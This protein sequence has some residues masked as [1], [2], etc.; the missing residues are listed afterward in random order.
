M[1]LT[2]AEARARAAAVSQVAYDIALDLTA[3]DAAGYGLRQEIAFTAH[4]SSTFL[5]LTGA[6]DLETRLDGRPVDVRYDG[7]RLHLDGLDA[8]R[9]RHRLV[10]TARLPY[11][12]DGAG[13]HRMVDPADGEVYLGAYVGVDVAQRVLCC[14]DQNDVKA[15]FTLA[16]ATQPGVTVIANGQPT[17]TSAEQADG[18][19]A[20]TTTPLLPPALFAVCA[21]RYVSHRFEHAGVPFAWHARA[22]LAAALERDAE[23]LQRITLQCYEHLTDLFDEPYPFDSYDQVFVPGLNWGALENAGCV[24]YRDELLPL[25]PPA[26]HQR[27]ARATV[28]AHEMSHMWFGDL[29]TMTWWEDTWLQESFADYMGVRVAAEA[30]GYVGAQAAFEVGQK[31]AVFEADRRRST[32][33]VAARPEDV[34]DVGT[35]LTIFDAISYGKGNAVLRQ[36]VT[37]LGDAAFLRGVNAYLTRHRLGNAT[38]ADLVDALAEAAPADRDVRAWAQAWLRTT[39][40]DEIVVHRGDDVPVLRRRGTRPHRLTVVGYDEGLREV[41]RRVVD[42]ADDPVALVDLRGRVVVVDAL[43]ETYARVVPDD[44]SASHLRAGLTRLEDPLVRAVLWR[45]G[46]LGAPDDVLTLVRDHLPHETDPTIAAAV[47]GRVLR[48]TLPGL[49]AGRVE[50]ALTVVAAACGDVLAATE[51]VALAAAVLPGWTAGSRAVGALERALETGRVG[52]ADLGPTDR[53]DVLAR[54][55]ALGERTPEHLE[56]ER[57]RSPGLDADL[58]ALRARAA[59]PTAQAKAEAWALASAPDVDNRRFGALL[60]GLWSSDRT[61][62]AAPYVRRY[63]DEAP[64]WTERGGAFA[65]TVGRSGPTFRP[66]SDDVERLRARLNAAQPPL[67]TVLRRAWSDWLDDLDHR[68]A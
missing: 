68:H 41:G 27:V 21:G 24:T 67:A 11:V 4:A 19:W 30:A 64:G 48:R 8:D 7:R 39:G 57:R 13:L 15:T 34:P 59:V 61:G 16:V 28:I 66:A 50:D 29:V 62:S 32:H 42:L 60:A 17:T 9:G 52:V 20:F 31:P 23:E 38:L 35:A 6:T 43:G 26:E 46:L 58:G 22:S 14:F 5:E 51:D 36:L 1:T 3:P 55:A 47:V 63:L 44:V 49:P 33:P 54:L 25:A 2:L 65:Q 18:V 37:W 12:S 40:A 45:E 53:W 10:V 56:A